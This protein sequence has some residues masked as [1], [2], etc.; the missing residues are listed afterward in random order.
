MLLVIVL[1][2]PLSYASLQGNISANPPW[3]EHGDINPQAIR[4]G[5]YFENVIEFGTKEY[6]SFSL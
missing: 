5:V 3:N 2:C 4:F 1:F 6:Q